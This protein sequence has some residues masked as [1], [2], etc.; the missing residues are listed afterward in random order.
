MAARM[1]TIKL[2]DGSGMIR[3]VDSDNRELLKEWLFENMEEIN[4]DPSIGGNWLMWQMIEWK[5]VPS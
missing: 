1:V 5:D 4:Q 2:K 3:Q